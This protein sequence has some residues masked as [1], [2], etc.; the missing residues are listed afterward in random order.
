[1]KTL[2]RT[3]SL[4]LVLVMVLGFFGVA[5]AAF[6]DQ[7]EV[8][9]TEAVE[10]MAGIGAINGY[11]DGTFLP[12]GNVTREEA[13]KIVAYS[14]LGKGVA[15]KLTVSATGFKDVAADRWSA[16]YISY[17]VGKGVINGMGDGT[18]APTANVTGYQMAKMMLVAAGYGA[19]GEFTG[20]GWELAVAVAGNKAK[21]FAGAS[22]V[23]YTK[24]ATREEATLY[25]FNGII[26]VPQVSYNKLF[27]QYESVLHASGTM[28]GETVEIAEEVYSSLKTVTVPG[29]IDGMASYRWMYK[30]QYISAAYDDASVL[31]T[32][33]NGTA[34]ALLTNNAKAEYIGYEAGD[35]VKYYLNGD[36]STRAA[37]D[38]VITDNNG[39]IVKFIDEGTDNKYDTI[40]VTKDTITEVTADPITKTSGTITYIT[41]PGILS[42]ID[43][44]KVIGDTNVAKGDYVMWHKDSQN[45]YFITGVCEKF[46]GTLNAFNI[47]GK[48]LVIDGTQYKVSGLADNTTTMSAVAGLAATTFYKDAAG[49]VCKAVA[50]TDIVDLKNV[51]YV[52]GTSPAGYAV[53]A[54]VAFPDGTVTAI[55]VAKINT[56]TAAPTST[57][58]TN[59]PA[60]KFYTF[61]KND[62]GSFNLKSISAQYSEVVHGSVNAYGANKAIFTQGA[63]NF[64]GD[65]DGAPVNTIRGTAKTQFVVNYDVSKYTAYT[66]VANMPTVKTKDPGTDLADIRAA[67]LSDKDGYALFAVAYDNNENDAFDLAVSGVKADAKYVFAY[68][69]GTAVWDAKLQQ[70]YYKFFAVVNGEITTIDAVDAHDTITDNALT[71]G[72][73]TTIDTYENGRVASTDDGGGYIDTATFTAL[74]DAATGKFA[75]SFKVNGTTVTAY[76]GTSPVKSFI[77]DDNCKFFIY[78][79]TNMKD[80]KLTASS[81]EELATLT[82]NNEAYMLQGVKKSTDNGAITQ[83]FVTKVDTSTPTTP[84]TTP[85]VWATEVAKAY[86]VD[87]Y[88]QTDWTVA[89]AVSA[90]EADLVAKGWTI[91]NKSVDASGIYTFTVAKTVLGSLFQDTYTFDSVNDVQ[92]V[93]KTGTTKVVV[94]G[95]GYSASD[96]VVTKDKEYAPDNG[97]VTFTVKFVGT[98]DTNDTATITPS[99]ANAD[100]AV[101]GSITATNMTKDKTF[102]CSMA[103]NAK[104]M[105]ETTITIA[106]TV[107]S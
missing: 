96:F 27:D 93:F 13:A 60:E 4:V 31:A 74:N 102:T 32:S 3:L 88:A 107:N 59:V 14:V 39:V 63:A 30:G 78:D 18:F 77:V 69:P 48:V 43:S 41:I 29:T 2:N 46:T 105:G 24:P 33:N 89:K 10:V 34:L 90:V 1:M 9:Y 95:T 21:V 47:D 104:D 103:V 81:K 56:A 11:T 83:L 87:Y 35:T 58:T 25:A 67:V 94:S 49:Y 53:Q 79:V 6:K 84:V 44:T 15:D 22:G 42:N 37:V 26:N 52:L 73:L 71:V 23:D 19:K 55:P 62:N 12:K 66:G 97:V 106:V 54:L 100:T 91:A 36:A 28:K 16:P 80:P 70:N 98:T 17:L 7:G 40:A 51:V 72:M 85:G 38:A 82:G 20:S 86:S 92:E 99:N 75:T 101:N 64:L 65:K 61:T 45:R 68:L 57:T 5:G 76:K 8:K 50:A